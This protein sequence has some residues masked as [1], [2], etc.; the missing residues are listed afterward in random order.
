MGADEIAIHPVAQRTEIVIEPRVSLA[1]RMAL[2]KVESGEVVS[3]R[4]LTVAP[5]GRASHA[6]QCPSRNSPSPVAARRYLASE[7]M[8]NT[9]HRERRV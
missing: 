9:L 7:K 3:V 4:V 6:W 1:L 5:I 8:L 2:E